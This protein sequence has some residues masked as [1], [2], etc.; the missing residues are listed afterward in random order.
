VVIYLNEWNLRCFGEMPPVVNAKTSEDIYK[1]M[2]FLTDAS[3]RRSIG[4]KGRQFVLR[5]NHPRVVA[6]SL[7]ELYR[8]ILE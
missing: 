4:E 3:E 8:G 5:H 7:I 1:A 2:V 6:D